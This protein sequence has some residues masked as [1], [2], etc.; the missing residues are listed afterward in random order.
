MEL[1]ILKQPT[2]GI[3]T[4]KESPFIEANTEVVALDDL[5]DIHIIPVF[6][7]DNSPLI[8]Q[9]DFIQTTVDIVQDVSGKNTAAPSIRVSHAIKGRIPEA[10]N[11][12]ASELLEH[13][14]TIY[15]ERMAF[16]AE[17]PTY[18]EQVNGQELTMTVGGIKAYNE[19]NLYNVG[20]AFQRFRVFIGFKV[21]VC[22]NLSI[23]TD[24][25][26]QELKV[27]SLTELG[28]KIHDL[29]QGYQS[30]T[31]LNFLRNLTDYE[32][33]EQQFA[34]LIGKARLYHHLPNDRK[35]E[36]PELLISDSQISTVA[37]QY[38]KD[39]HF[40]GQIEKGINLWNLYN[41]L[42]DSV[43][44]SYIDTFLDRNANALSFTQGIAQALEGKGNYHWF[45]N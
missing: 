31:H 32:L 21:K 25:Y 4:P 38:Y 19:D 18:K 7:K 15:Y 40:R 27:R 43:K 13:E 28:E 17:I 33:T 1:Q 45:L 35:K 42:T 30:E 6:V 44:S 39:E 24:G 9:L 10:R 14:K 5:R 41:L 12:K 8:S 29:V 11:K 3:S 26:S 37:R 23:W 36:V 22:T 34:M 16:I 20:G 2:N